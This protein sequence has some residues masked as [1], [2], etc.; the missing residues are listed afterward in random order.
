M[1]KK[2]KCTEILALSSCDLFVLNKAKLQMN[3]EMPVMKNIKDQSEKTILREQISCFK[4]IVLSFFLLFVLFNLP[5]ITANI[6]IQLFPNSFDTFEDA[7]HIC[8]YC[9]MGFVLITG[10]IT[11][12]IIQRRTT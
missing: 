2:R 12:I 11:L 3:M 10:A 4:N 5:F 1:T 8:G 6:A 9:L 7:I